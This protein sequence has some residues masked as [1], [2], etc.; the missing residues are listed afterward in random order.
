MESEEAVVVAERLLTRRTTLF[1]DH[2]GITA[3]GMTAVRAGLPAGA[4]ARVVKN[5]IVVLVAGRSGVDLPAEVVGGPVALVSTD[6]DPAVLA[7][8]VTA[9]PLKVRA[10][11][12]EGVAGGR[13]PV[14]A[15]AALRSRDAVLARLAGT[16]TAPLGRFAAVLE[17]AA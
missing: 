11:I 8:A 13:E 9:G 14:A 10:G 1:V 3:A 6:G 2:T 15:V 12:V 16:L 7:A 5:R 17:A 4:E